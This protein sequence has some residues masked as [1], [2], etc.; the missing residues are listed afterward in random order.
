MKSKMRLS[1]LSVAILVAALALAVGMFGFSREL[2]QRASHRLL[3]SQAA[4]ARTSVT[5][6]VS[7]FE[8][9]LSS[10]GS[11][12]A[13]TDASP[14]ALGKLTSAVPSLGLFTTLTVLHPSPSGPPAVI[15][16]RGNPSAPLGDLGGATAQ[17]L[18]KVTAR[19]GFVFL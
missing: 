7:L 13:A 17:G 14:A 18:E 6:F 2:N 19:G 10:A 12:A 11:V 8:S 1:K 9:T 5:S 15:E 16:V 4:D 3:T